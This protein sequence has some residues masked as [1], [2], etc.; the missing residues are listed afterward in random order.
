[1][2]G[3]GGGG[4]GAGGAGG[5]ASAGNGVGAA[6]GATAAQAKANGPTVKTGDVEVLGA[7]GNSQGM[8]NAQGKPVPPSVS[9]EPPGVGKSAETAKEQG[10][11]LESLGKGGSTAAI[12]PKTGDV[13]VRR[14][15]RVVE[16]FA[17]ETVIDEFADK[18]RLSDVDREALRNLQL[19]EEAKRRRVLA[20]IAGTLAE[21]AEERARGALGARVASAPVNA[22]SELENSI[23]VEREKSRLRE[24]L[25]RNDAELYAWVEKQRKAR[26]EPIEAAA[27]AAATA[28]AAAKSA[29]A[30]SSDTIE[31]EA[32]FASPNAR[33]TVIPPEIGAQYSQVGDKFYHPNNTKTVAFVDRGDKLETPSSA[34]Q[35]AQ[36]LVKIAEARGWDDLKVKG[37]EGFRREVWLEASVR[38]I[39]VDGYKPS[40]LDKLELEKRNT[41]M[42]DRNSVEVRSEAYKK[43]S[44]Q[45]GVRRDPT[46]AAAYGT[47]AAARRLAERMHPEN[48]D[49]F[50]QSVKTAVTHKLEA[51][52]PVAIKLKVP[53]GQLIEHG[54]ANYN[55]DKD[56]KPSYYVKLAEANGRER[57]YWGAGLQKAMASASPQPGDTVQLRVTESK[58]VVVEGNVRDAAGQVVGRQTVDSHRN[59]WQAAVTAK[60]ASQSRQEP[61]PERDRV[62]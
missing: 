24:N 22:P 59:E 31:R 20:D 54:R 27:I 23:G 29:E 58:G 49:A 32:P 46:L 38:G 33:I 6:P 45:E 5:G 35:M 40:E 56:E 14:S 4:G 10:V 8:F 42:Q 13:V 16:R 60:A 7:D 51:G 11:R 18:K 21:S 43:L 26:V 44:P 30:K 39:H 55:F 48:R 2:A 47:E 17:S 34:P 19:V 1:M 15:G 62:R 61:Q 52:E 36:S 12:D 41:F 3:S 9:F 28:G 50:V 25:Q 37:T 57:I 53:E